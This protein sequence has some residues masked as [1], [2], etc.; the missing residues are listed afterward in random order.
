MA[1]ARV[2]Q[3]VV[4]VLVPFA[5]VAVYA[6]EY[7]KSYVSAVNEKIVTGLTETVIPGCDLTATGTPTV[8]AV[9]WDVWVSQ[10]LSGV[11]K[12]A[13]LRVRRTD[14]SGTVL[15]STIIGD[16]GDSQAGHQAEWNSSYADSAPTDYRYVFTVQETAGNASAEIWS[17][18]KSFILCTNSTALVSQDVVEVLGS[19]PGS[20]R[21]GQ[22][23]VEVLLTESETQS[24]APEPST[25]SGGVR[26]YG[27]A[28]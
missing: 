17:N 25:S 20:V 21:V 10:N 7:D 22:F 3:H 6:A 9:F 1:K 14:A 11:A 27:H 16:S 15:A 26:A 5:P 13:T 18:S 12:Q 19:F 2:S 23:I 4:E 8:V 28:G 24:P